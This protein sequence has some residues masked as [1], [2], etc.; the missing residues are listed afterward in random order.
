MIGS[1]HCQ[2][3]K[4]CTWGKPERVSV[5][6]IRV[7]RRLQTAA[8]AWHGWPKQADLTK[9]PTDLYDRGW[10]GI[11]TVLQ[12]WR[13]MTQISID[14]PAASTCSNWFVRCPIWLTKKGRLQGLASA[15]WQKVLHSVLFGSVSRL[16]RGY[17]RTQ[18]YPLHRR[19]RLR[20]RLRQKFCLS[21]K[22][23]THWEIRRKKQE[24]RNKNRKKPE[25]RDK[26][27]QT[28]IMRNKK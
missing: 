23:K 6:N 13:R 18:H 25:I 2:I 1:L 7:S 4:A 20:T 12:Q 10:I 24:T 17:L 26:K 27:R 15:P 22:R 3:C 8:T 19:H 21:R 11:N 5:R 9:K 14:F 16:C 28:I